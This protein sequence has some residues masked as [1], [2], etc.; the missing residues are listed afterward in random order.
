VCREIVV[1]LRRGCRGCVNSSGSLAKL[2]AMRRA[3]RGSSVSTIR[4]PFLPKRCRSWRGVVR[5]CRWLCG[6]RRRRVFARH[7][8]LYLRAGVGVFA[9]NLIVGKIKNAGQAVYTRARTRLRD[10]MLDGQQ[11]PRPPAASRERSIAAL[12][13]R[14]A[15][16]QQKPKNFGD[17][18]AGFDRAVPLVLVA[19]SPAKGAGGS[20]RPARSKWPRRIHYLRWTARGRG[21]GGG[22]GPVNCAGRPAPSGRRLI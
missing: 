18:S 10:D 8:S 13:L 9:A 11:V 22:T 20:C 19:D 5:R 6:V 17:D 16:E 1:A 12:L 7:Q 4:R 21:A 2:A 15:R 14:M 3:H